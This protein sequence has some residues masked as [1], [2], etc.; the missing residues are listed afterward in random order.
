[1]LKNN[2]YKYSPAKSTVVTRKHDCEKC[3][4]NMNQKPSMS[5]TKP[6]KTS[7]NRLYSLL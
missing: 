7:K 6:S 5:R 3:K 4:N 1:M 2:Y